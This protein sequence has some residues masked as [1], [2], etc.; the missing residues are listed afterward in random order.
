MVDIK[1]MLLHNTRKS[2]FSLFFSFNK[3]STSGTPKKRVE[4]KSPK[5]YSTIEITFTNL[6]IF[7][8]IILLGGIF[9]ELMVDKKDELI[10]RLVH[11]F[12]TEKNYSPIVVNGVKDEIWLQNQEGPYKII[13]INGNYIHNKEQYEFDIVKI[14]NVMHQV[15]RKTLSWSMNALN[16]LL[17][18]NEEVPLEEV[19][20]I[21]SV[22]VKNIHDVN[23]KIFQETFPDIDEKLLLDEKG[24]DLIIDVTKGINEKTEKEN[25]IY[26]SIFKPKKIVATHILILV[27]VLLFIFTYALSKANL[28]AYELL[29]FGGLY[30]PYVKEGEVWRLITSGFLHGGL[31]HLLFNM[32]SLYLIGTQIENFI[33]KW[34]FLIIYF[35]SMISA[36]LMSC[37]INSNVVSVGASG[38]IFG[39][40][41]SLLY[42]GYHYRLYLGSILRNQIVPVILINL[43]LG[44]SLSG[45]DNAAHIGGLLGGLL[46]AIA[47]GVQN[48]E[49][50][51][52]KLN[53]WI[54]LT[55]YFVF[56][57][58]LIFFR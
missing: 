18:V 13:R 33:G 4:N 21:S 41:G 25:K 30:A 50:K 46:I 47:L 34:K 9:M 37:V 57:L 40:L 24:F 35:V 20:G 10:M 6:M 2:K 36:G 55:I 28:S 17:D 32:Y 12:I 7:G 43:I 11:Y 19:K 44:F 42:F 1:N 5:K 52:N 45:I 54:C 15:K 39:L 49:N 3:E 56:F 38:A 53:G 51:S 31:L 26:E 16:I 29:R 58:Y 14:K 23:G 22:T 8:K 27:N 48:K